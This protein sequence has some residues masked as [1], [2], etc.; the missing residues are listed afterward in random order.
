MITKVQLLK[1]FLPD[2]NYIPNVNDYVIW[3]C[4]NVKG[5]VY[6]KGSSYV[7][8]EISVR[9]KGEVD[10]SNCSIHLNYRVLVL[11]YSNCWNELSYVKSRE[12]V[13]DCD[14]N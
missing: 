7:T 2:M 10:C 6:H 1:H 12:S 3:K 13:Y 9:Q 11:C 8:I 14:I 5:W 4:K